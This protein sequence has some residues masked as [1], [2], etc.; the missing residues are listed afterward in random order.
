M[1]WQVFS[2]DRH[3]PALVLHETGG[4]KTQCATAQYGTVFVRC[5]AGQFHGEMGRAP[6]QGNAAA[7]MP[8]VV[9]DDLVV[10]SFGAHIEAI[11]PKRPQTCDGA[12]D[13]LFAHVH[14]AHRQAR[15]SVV[16]PVRRARTRG[17]GTGGYGGSEGGQ[18]S[19]LKYCSSADHG[20]S[21][22]RN[23]GLA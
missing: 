21:A 18:G 14:P 7:T 6:T 2:I 1:G 19:C 8:V 11:P 13:P 16:A 15:G 9:Y 22:R 5:L 3:L 4:R 17:N 23:F 10:T 20:E 12:N